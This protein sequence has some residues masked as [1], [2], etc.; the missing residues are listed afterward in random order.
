MSD[1]L[2]LY[3]RLQTSICNF[4]IISNSFSILTKSLLSSAFL[5][6]I[7]G[8]IIEGYIRRTNFVSYVLGKWSFF[9]SGNTWKQW[10]LNPKYSRLPADVQAS[11]NFPK[12][13]FVTF[14]RFCK[15]WFTETVFHVRKTY[16]ARQISVILSL[17]WFLNFEN[18]KAFPWQ[19][20]MKNNIPCLVCTPWLVRTEDNKWAQ[21]SIPWMVMR[22]EKATVVGKLDCTMHPLEI[23][24]TFI[25]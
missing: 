22:P 16:N 6:S 13:I 8:G 21:I 20:M 2:A 9:H 4:L 17:N 25:H 1:L 11:R 7:S 23:N 5:H 14:T 18:Q 10:S 19:R 3:N 24:E 15:I 12:T